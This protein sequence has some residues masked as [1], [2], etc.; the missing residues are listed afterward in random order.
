[1]QPIS[2]GP[3]A[4][5]TLKCDRQLQAHLEA[6]GLSSIAE[7]G[8]WCVRYGLSPRLAKHWRDRCRER[9][10]ASQNAI[11]KR[12]ARTK[13]ERRRPRQ[14]LERIFAGELDKAEVKQPTLR[15][16][17]QLLTAIET[18]EVAQAFRELLL[19]VQRDCDL[20]AAQPAWLSLG[21]V[22][23]NTFIEGLLA[24]ARRHE[25]WIRPLS[26]WQPQSHNPRRQFSALA[27]HLLARFPV[28]LF[29]DSVWFRGTSPEAT[30]QQELYLA[31]GSGQSPRSCDLPMPLSRRM[32]HFFLHAPK[33][34][35]VEQSLRYAQVMNLGGD[36]RLVQAVLGSRLGTCFDNSGFWTTVIRWLVH[37][38]MLDPAQVGPLIDFIHHQRLETEPDNVGQRSAAVQP[39]FTMKGRSAAALLAQ[40]NQWHE[41]LRKKSGKPPLTWP[42]SGIGGFEL[43]EGTLASGNLRRWTIVE[44]LSCQALFHEGQVMK[45]CVASYDASCSFGRSSI[46][47]LGVEK[48]GGRRKNVLTIE[49]SN[50]RR[51]IC[52]A[53]GKA[54]RLPSDNEIDVLRRWA[55][56]EELVLGWRLTI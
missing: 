47:S 31:L 46:W 4:D 10:L 24:V 37:N 32:I 15:L 9:Y 53:R 21:A 40:M 35:L 33:D 54:N 49:I 30:K 22:A 3:S 27:G 28:P 50:G 42:A 18:Q 8:Q 45:H 13:A 48:N 36:M 52:Q 25:R 17:H 44:L 2:A 34:F 20:I 43:V 41:R 51:T 7:Y 14:T 55:L 6:L 26:S 16:V 38:P 12:L 56:Q 29:L 39:E 1:M 11:E 23:G 19:H 5:E